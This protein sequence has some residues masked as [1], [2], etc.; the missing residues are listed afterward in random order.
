MNEI[1]FNFSGASKHRWLP[2]RIRPFVENSLNWG[3][4]QIQDRSP[5]SRPVASH[6][7]SQTHS[8]TTGL[9][10]AIATRPWYW[11]WRHG[12]V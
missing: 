12:Q 3:V 6:N 7:Q 9:G 11:C 1:V 4:L 10:F 8:D 5:Q 2:F